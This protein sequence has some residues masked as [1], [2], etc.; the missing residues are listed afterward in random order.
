MTRRGFLRSTGT[1]AALAAGGPLL[2]ACGGTDKGKAPP[3]S[4][5]YTPTPS[6]EV[7]YI[8]WES[9]APKTIVAPYEELG[10]RIVMTFMGSIDEMYGKLRASGGAGY[11][12]VNSTSDVVIPMAQAGL[13][14]PIDTSSMPNYKNVRPQLARSHL[15]EFNGKTY[16]VPVDWGST[17]LLANSRRLGKLADVVPYDM[18]LDPQFRGRVTTMDDLSVIFATAAYMGYKQ[19]W[20]LTDQQL[21]DVQALLIDK[22]LPNVRKFSSTFADEANLFANDEVDVA[23]GWTGAIRQALLAAN[24]THVSEHVITPDMPWYVD[25]I[26]AVAKSDNLGTVANWMDYN[27]IP[28]V[29]ANRFK[30]NALPTVVPAAVAFLTPEQQSASYL[31]PDRESFWAKL[32]PEMQWHP[33]PRRSLYQSVWNSVKAGTR[34]FP[35]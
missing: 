22:L 10:A 25:C 15:W 13:I 31:T 8:C 34:Q 2:T 26:S 6:G 11:D 27:M 7:R 30:A 5:I 19:Y 16:A 1:V 20:A 9:F 33:V 23:W 12:A 35:G 3:T 24:V 28:E 14:A 29:A 32:D 18:F 4:A 21:S 17:V